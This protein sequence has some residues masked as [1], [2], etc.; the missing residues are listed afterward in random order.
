MNAQTHYKLETKPACIL[1]DGPEETD[2]DGGYC[3]SVCFG[4][5]H[6]GAITENP[7][8]VWHLWEYGEVRRFAAQ[9]GKRYGLEVIN[10]AMP[11]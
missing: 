11:A 7:N 10:E 1:A 6:G 4:D 5:D 9:L 3:Y 8:A 2:G